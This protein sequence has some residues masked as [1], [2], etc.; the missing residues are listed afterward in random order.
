MLQSSQPPC[1]VIVYCYQH[2]A[3]HSRHSSEMAYCSV[4][5]TNTHKLQQRNYHHRI[6]DVCNQ[7]KIIRIYEMGKFILFLLQNTWD[8]LPAAFAVLF[9]L[10]SGMHN[11]SLSVDLVFQVAKQHRPATS[12][13][14][15]RAGPGPAMESKPVLVCWLA[16]QSEC[17]TSEQCQAC[18]LLGIYMSKWWFQCYINVK[19]GTANY[20][21]IL[22]QTRTNRGRGTL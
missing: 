8:F 14:S 17:T 18:S 16:S 9:S 19:A 20:G 5:F 15:A 21:P 12:A 7:R 3:A 13:A 1:K 11:L 4:S 6:V 10:F 2:I 22:F